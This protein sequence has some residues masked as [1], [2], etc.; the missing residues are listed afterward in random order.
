MKGENNMYG[1]K[2]GRIQN[3]K[4]EFDDKTMDI[5]ITPQNLD[6][7][8]RNQ[9][10][11]YFWNENN[12]DQFKNKIEIKINKMSLDPSIP[13]KKLRREINSIITRE[14]FEWRIQYT[15][16]LPTK[17]IIDQILVGE[18][19]LAIPFIS[20]CC[21][22]DCLANFA[23]EKKDCMI[24]SYDECKNRKYDK[25]KNIWRCFIVEYFD[26]KYKSYVDSLYHG[27]RCGLV[28]SFR[29]Q[30][31]NTMMRIELVKNEK[32]EHLREQNGWLKLDIEQFYYDTKKAFEK[33][34]DKLDRDNSLRNRL[35]LR[36]KKYGIISPTPHDKKGVS[37]LYPKSDS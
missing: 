34:M 1:F 28:H 10:I 11:F 26:P 16:L 7:E 32:M 31:K 3:G 37:K 19:G 27:F 14:Y 29:S 24:N 6:N 21:I 25:N 8:R 4:P 12:R 20:L 36:Y 23:C 9:E 33:Y 30:S 13:D 2:V 18:L 5:N 17:M 15:I 35:Y 22:I